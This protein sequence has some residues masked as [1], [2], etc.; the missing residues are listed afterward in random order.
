MMTRPFIILLAGTLLSSTVASADR[1]RR[2]NDDDDESEPTRAAKRSIGGEDRRRAARAVEDDDRDATEDE[3]RPRKRKIRK[4]DKKERVA[5]S[6]TD[7]D[8][9][10]EAKAALPIK[11]SDLIDVT[12]RNS[13]NLARSKLNRIAAQGDAGAARL[14]QAWRVNADARYSQYGVGGDVDVDLAT[15]VQEQKI[16]TSLALGRKLPTGGEVE[17]KLAFNRTVKEFA[18]SKDF[19]NNINND[20]KA[21]QPIDE[22]TTSHQTI[23]SVSFTQPLMRGIGS[24]VALAKEH[25]ADLSLSEATLETQY[26]AEKT[27]L[28]LVK[29]YWE[30]AVAKYE[31]DVRL[32]A[33]ELAE[34]QEKFT[35]DEIRAGAAANTS[36]NAIVYELATR[37]EAR[38]RAESDLE[39]KSLELR[40]KAGLNLEN[41]SIVVHPDQDFVVGTEEYRVGD[42]LER[43][44]KANRRL[45]L[46]ALRRRNVDVDVK[47]AENAT[48]PQVDLS[49]SAGVMGTGASTDEAFSNASGI[50]GYQVMAGLKVQFEVS[51]A[52]RDAAKAAR[53]RRTAV[54]VERLEVEREI[55]T[56]VVAAVNEVRNARERVGF[57]EKAI[58]VAEENVK[59]ERA[60]F[61][62]QKSTNFD[63]MK[64][65][66]E[67]VE[68]MLRRGRAVADY[69]IAVGQL[70]FM[71]GTLLEAYGVD[72]L[73]VR[74]K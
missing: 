31:L 55:E 48:L 61:E 10:M 43:C 19:I 47:V 53:A 6:E 28:E 72:V 23:G 62:N 16:E 22:L 24:D 21:T 3:D 8:D 7:D 67:L 70:Q 34:R 40:R 11:L 33:V 27:V 52:A 25:K 65:Q 26:E 1:R 45:T 68:A 35:R 20:D 9:S 69:H 17:A 54:E 29:L 59:V 51:G 12:V 36:I 42:M 4:D 39:K 50:A 66:S 74:G 37:N 13:P 57:A 14:D 18:I 63:V 44:R 5:A 64:R 56:E 32:Q 46:L 38:L 2:A 15:V 58:A 41:R 73:P 71:S 49:L 30:T 60:Q